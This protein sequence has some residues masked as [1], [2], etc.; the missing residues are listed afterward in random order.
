MQKLQILNTREKKAI[1]DIINKQWGCDFKTDLVML[2][3]SKDKLYLMTRDFERIETQ[4]VRVD[5]MGNYFGMLTGTE[6]R[7][8]I[9]GSQMIGPQAK[10]NILEIDH[11]N[12]RLWLKGKDLKMELPEELSGFVI[13]KYKNDFLGTGKSRGDEILNFIPKNRRILAED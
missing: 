4:R 5:S 1:V 11:D 6:L 3:S 7:L 12:M 10:K 9:E 13:L 2:K 8:S